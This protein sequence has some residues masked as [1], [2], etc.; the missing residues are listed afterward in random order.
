MP[1]PTQK[2]ATLGRQAYSKSLRTYCLDML[3]ERTPRQRVSIQVITRQNPSTLLVPSR[4]QTKNKLPN[5]DISLSFS[6][7]AFLLIVR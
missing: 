6:T 7:N 1:C 5:I 4:S 3:V 2:T